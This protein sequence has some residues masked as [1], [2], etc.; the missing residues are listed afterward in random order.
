MVLY[1]LDWLEERSGLVGGVKYFLFRKVPRRHRL[2]AHA[3]LGDADRLPRPG[4]H[5][6][7][8]GDVLQADPGRG[9]R[10]DPAH[11]ER[12]RLR[13]ARA[14]HA[15]LGRERLH[16]PALLP[17]GA[18]LPVRRLQVPARAELDHRRLP[19]DPRHV[20]GLHRLPA[21]VR[22]DRVLGDGRRDE[23]HRERAVRRDR[24]RADHAGR[25]RDRGRHAGAVLL[26]AH[27]RRAG[28]DLRPDRAAPVPR[29]PARRQL[30]ALVE[31]GRRRR[32]H[33]A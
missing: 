18:G 28:R 5:R 15:P 30:A 23:H 7:D 24:A 4:D 16:H 8:P 13:L 1:P 33:R 14:R 22:P 2:G 32:A 19:A 6:R 3:R 10:V 20:R 29:D 12:R 27:A 31:G 11:H 25:P 9:V 21:P 26:A 17:H